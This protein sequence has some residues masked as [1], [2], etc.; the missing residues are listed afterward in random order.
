MGG[1]VPCFVHCFPSE[2]IIYFP[3]TQYS[4]PSFKP[5]WEEGPFLSN[6]VPTPHQVL[7]FLEFIEHN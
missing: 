4:I 3:F 1:S 2:L 6:P 5:G 7:T